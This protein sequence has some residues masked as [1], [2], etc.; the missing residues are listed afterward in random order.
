LI[1]ADSF[2]PSGGSDGAVLL[3]TAFRIRHI[4]RLDEALDPALPASTP[5]LAVALQRLS[6]PKQHVGCPVALLKT[7]SA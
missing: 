7:S 2:L 3:L 6:A 4:V 1:T 5:R